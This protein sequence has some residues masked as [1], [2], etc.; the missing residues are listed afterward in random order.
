MLL[1]A[2]TIV[3]WF[4]IATCFILTRFSGWLSQEDDETSSSQTSSTCSSGSPT[5]LLSP[6]LV[7][8][9][10]GRRY[11][12]GRPRANSIPSTPSVSSQA[13]I[14][15][16]SYLRTA[17]RSS[18]VDHRYSTS[19]SLPS[20]LLFCSNTIT[21]PLLGRKSSSFVVLPVPM[22][23]VCVCLIFLSV[24]TATLLNLLFRTVFPNH[25]N[26]CILAIDY[27]YECL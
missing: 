27:I 1:M 11:L 22:C 19:F 4:R 21:P 25:C 16:V 20:L 10:A 17:S 9:E 24:S 12:N 14:E 5:P 13:S 6:R 15:S 7:L 18:D 8:N 3:G 23:G 2:E 26:V